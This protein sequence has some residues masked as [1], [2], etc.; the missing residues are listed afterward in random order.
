M[1][2]VDLMILL[3]HYVLFSIV[4]F[5][6]NVGLLIGDEDVEVIGV[7]IVL[8]CMLEVVNE[9][10]EKGYNIIISYY[11]LIFKGVILLKVNGYGLIIRKLI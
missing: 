4:E 1:K 10:I 5:W 7:L 8:D 6:D 2:I 9:V 11:F 3:D